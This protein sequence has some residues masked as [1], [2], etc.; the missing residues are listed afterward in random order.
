MR[1]HTRFTTGSSN[2]SAARRKEP[3]LAE[4]WD[5][6]ADGK[7]YTFNLRPGVKFQTTEYF[8]PTRELN[9]DDV[10]F[11]FERQYKEDNPFWNV[12]TSGLTWDYFQG[13]DMPKYSRKIEKVDDLTVKITLNEPN[14]PMI[15]NLGMDF[16]SIV[17]KE[18]ADQLA[19]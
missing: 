3:A 5:I 18:Y 7:E 10:I 19:G 14:A 15:A 11:S 13:M 2:S 16:A 12:C 6:S 8:T 9:A 4:S 17:S 1:P